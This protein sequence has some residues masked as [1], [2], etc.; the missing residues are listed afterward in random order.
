LAV[1]LLASLQPVAAGKSAFYSLFEPM[2]RVPSE[3]PSS[4][5]SFT[6]GTLVMDPF[7]VRGAFFDGDLH[8]RSAIEFHAFAPL[9]ALPG[10]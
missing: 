8:S 10:V 6:G 3:W 5:K 2:M 9:E 1:L 4:Y 7:N